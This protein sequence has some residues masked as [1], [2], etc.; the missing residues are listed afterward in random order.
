MR[1]R[2]GVRY[3][4]P[5]AD[6]PI[7]A[8][9]Y[10]RMMASAERHG[11]GERRGRLLG[12]ARGRVL[13]IG[14]GTGLN[15]PHY[16]AGQVGSV[17]AL[18]PDGAM[19][20]RLLPRVAAAP[21]PCRVEE[22]GIDEARFADGSFDTIVASLVLCTIPDPPG[23]AARLR[24]WLAPDGVLLFLEH[25]RAVGWRGRIQA[26]VSPLWS[27]LAGGCRLDRETLGTLREAGFFV[28]DCERFALPGG[29]VLLSACVQGAA[30]PRPVVALPEAS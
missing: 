4:S 18:E 3:G 8:A 28:T 24:R 11:L 17:V 13:E 12:E 25:V 15:L 5:V 9:L 20:R 16:V 6:H 2:G 23:A 14:A 19:R 22:A 29:G 1:S 26:A 30:R 21:V 7:Y 27:R 10:D